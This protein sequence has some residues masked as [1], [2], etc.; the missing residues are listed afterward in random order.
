[1]KLV[2]TDRRESLSL[3]M[4]GPH[5]HQYGIVVRSR[6]GAD[7]I[8]RIELVSPSRGTALIMAETG[9]GIGMTN[10]NLLPR[11]GAPEVL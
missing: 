7:A 1:M 4:V 3:T 2:R 10:F 5:F 8:R 11:S 6:A 9:T